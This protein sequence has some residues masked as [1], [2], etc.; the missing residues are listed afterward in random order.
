MLLSLFVL[1]MLIAL[2]LVFALAMDE[3]IPIPL[4]NLANFP[5][6]NIPGTKGL[7]FELVFAACLA[8]LGWLMGS[9]AA[10]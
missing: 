6:K 9:G 4:A 10:F 8:L 2:G 1:V 7:L 5:L 3:A